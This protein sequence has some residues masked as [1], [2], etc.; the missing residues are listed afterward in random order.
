MHELPDEI[1]FDL[2]RRVRSARLR[3]GAT[4]G[5]IAAATGISTSTLSRIELGKGAAVPLASWVTV[6]Q[7][8]GLDLFRPLHIDADVYL[9]AVT[10]LMA[11]GGWAP[12]GRSD[13]GSWF[14]RP[15]RPSPH[16]QHVQLPHERVL[17]RI[18]PTV[19]DL[20]V[21]VK[22]L[23]DAVRRSYES[24]PPGLEVEGL[25]IIP[26]STN[27]RRRAL[28]TQR[29]SSMGWIAA[30]RSSQVRMPPIR[31]V[32]WL[33]YRGTNWLPAG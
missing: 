33:A 14:D 24:T 32:V 12:S 8:V 21:A 9:A 4:Q 18:E 22:R 5:E 28:P 11:I 20:S 16:F 13:D 31:G 3:R 15:A 7:E 10:N 30:L 2:G 6:A 27:N 17:V 19:T 26:R 1:A 23:V 29:L 25:L